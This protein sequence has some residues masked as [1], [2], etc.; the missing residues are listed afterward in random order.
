MKS[1]SAASLPSAGPPHTTGPASYLDTH[2][3]TLQT[4]S[5]GGPVDS[6]WPHVY[7]QTS[8]YQMGLG[9][10]ILSLF[11]VTTTTASDPLPSSLVKGVELTVSLAGPWQNQRIRKQC[12]QWSQ[13]HP[14]SG[15]LLRSS[16]SLWALFRQADD[17]CWFGIEWR[18]SCE[19]KEYTELLH[20]S[21]FLCASSGFRKGMPWLLLHR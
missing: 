7:I 18:A 5:M 9:G 4:T 21:I 19:E 2:T 10:D 6:W 17:C 14:E 12:L 16:S 20:N 15:M 11:T 8:L 1:A 3:H 13:P